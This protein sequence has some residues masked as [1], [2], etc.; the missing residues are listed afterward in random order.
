MYAELVRR[1]ARIGITSE[2]AQV[3]LTVYMRAIQNADVV[4]PAIKAAA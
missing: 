1:Y 2:Q 3:M 4:L